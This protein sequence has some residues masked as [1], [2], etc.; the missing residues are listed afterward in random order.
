MNIPNFLTVLRIILTPVLVIFLME[1]RFAFALAIFVF[2]GITDAL[3]GFL[4]RILKQKTS[5]G[6]ILDPLADKALVAASFVTLSVLGILPGWLTVVVISRDLIILLGISV[7]FF[8]SISVDIKPSIISKATTV[9][10]FLT[11][12]VALLDR[13]RPVDHQSVFLSVTVWSTVI[14][15]TISGFHYIYKGIGLFNNS[16]SAE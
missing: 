1:G 9:S 12:L 5:I 3:D 6:S 2:S 7:L 4:A 10:Q 16:S 15:S 14:L 13:L 8:L 11:I